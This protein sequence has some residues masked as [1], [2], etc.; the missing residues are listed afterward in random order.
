MPL[1]PKD[2]DT[3]GNAGGD[4]EPCEITE[5]QTEGRVGSQEMEG[6]SITAN[7][8]PEWLQAYAGHLSED[9]DTD[10]ELD[11]TDDSPRSSAARVEPRQQTTGTNTQTQVTPLPTVDEGQGPRTI[12]N[13]GPRSSESPVHMAGA[14]LTSMS[15]RTPNF[16]LQAQ[17]PQPEEPRL[18][19]DR[20]SITVDVNDTFSSFL[21]QMPTFAEFAELTP[22]E[23]PIFPG[24]SSAGLS[25]VVD[26][27]DMWSDIFNH[28][29]LK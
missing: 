7:A 13:M 18:G 24:L 10:E 6:E 19:C 11:A 29:M 4:N 27:S 26:G 12:M 22:A 25:S 2:G 14:I 16:S 28:N 21:S 20:G 9:I 17:E 15:G 3:S 1:D 8:G 23:M 5:P